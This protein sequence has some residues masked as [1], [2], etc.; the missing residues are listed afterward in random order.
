MS[1]A[2]TLNKQYCITKTQSFGSASFCCPKSNNC[3]SGFI[4]GIT[5]PSCAKKMP[6]AL[7]VSLSDKEIVSLTEEARRTGIRQQ[8]A[9]EPQSSVASKSL[10]DLWLYRISRIDTLRKKGYNRTITLVRRK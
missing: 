4:L 2:N 1:Y 5:K 8:G 6:E 3:S 10:T 9:W 7:K